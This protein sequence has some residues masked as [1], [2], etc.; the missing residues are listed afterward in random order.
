MSRRW[1]ITFGALLVVGC[2]GD[3]L[4]NV[5]MTGAG[6]AIGRIVAVVCGVALGFVVMVL[7]RPSDDEVATGRTAYLARPDHERAAR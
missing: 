6:A 7:I 5:A 3:W 4:V 1:W 2:L